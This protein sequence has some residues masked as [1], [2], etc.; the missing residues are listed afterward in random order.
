MTA[1]AM[2]FDVSV[3]KV[4]DGVDSVVDISTAYRKYGAH[5]TYSFCFESHLPLSS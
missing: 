1:T 2:A 3:E 4:S 5:L